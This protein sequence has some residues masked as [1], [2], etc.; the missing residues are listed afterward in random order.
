MGLHRDGSLY[1]FSPVETHVRR[2]VWYHLCFL[3]LRTCEATGPRPQIRKEDFDTKIPLNVNENDLLGNVSPENAPRFTDMTVS[4]IRFECTEMHRQIWMDWPRVDQK[5]LKV[6][7]VLGRIQKFRADMEARYL[8]LLQGQDPRQ[9]LGMHMYRILSSRLVIMLLHRY[10]TNRAQPMPDRLRNILID[11]SL[12]TSEYSI[13]LDTRPEL[14]PW[15][16]YRG[17]VMQYHSALLLLMVVRVAPQ[18][19]GADRIWRCLDFVFELPPKMTPQQKI[20]LVLGNLQERM[21][22]YQNMRKL[23]ATKEAEQRAPKMAGS[24]IATEEMTATSTGVGATEEEFS[25]NSYN[26]ATMDPKSFGMPPLQPLYSESAGDTSSLTAASNSSPGDMNMQPMDDI[27]WVSQYM[28][29][30]SRRVVLMSL[31][32]EWEQ[33]FPTDT[34]MNSDFPAS[35]GVVDLPELNLGS[36]TSFV[37]HTQSAPWNT[38]TAGAS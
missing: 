21:T 28:N 26:S 17:A 25:F 16:W 23:K 32:N 33:W 31:Q 13:S 5:R 6:A 2:L 34:D 20:G 36:F 27:D 11:A 15:A 18:I 30:M 8:P 12:A 3:D 10:L 22:M 14:A 35:F 7:T 38:D 37:G 4:R 24:M 9:S 19:P 29:D 1:N